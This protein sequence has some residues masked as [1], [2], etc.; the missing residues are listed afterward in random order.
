M[1][2]FKFKADQHINNRKDDSEAEMGYM[3]DDLFDL[4]VNASDEQRVVE[5]V[6]NF[7]RTKNPNA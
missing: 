4:V 2:T 6:L 5:Q 3:N 1:M 7:I